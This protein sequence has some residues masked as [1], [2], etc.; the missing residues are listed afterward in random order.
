MCDICKIHCK[1]LK[2]VHFST[3]I[4]SATVKIVSR[5]NPQTTVVRKNLLIR[6]GKKPWA[7]PGLHEGPSSWW[8]QAT[9]TSEKWIKV[10]SIIPMVNS[11]YF[12]KFE[13]VKR[14]FFSASFIIFSNLKSQHFVFYFSGIYTW[15][16][17]SQK[18]HFLTEGIGTCNWQVGFFALVC[19]IILNVQTMNCA[20]CLCSVWD[21]GL[22]WIYSSR[23]NQHE[24]QR[25]V[26][27]WNKNNR[28]AER[29][30]KLRVI[31][32]TL[33]TASATI[34]N[35]PKTKDTTG[36]LSSHTGTPG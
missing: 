7:G 18:Q 2:S 5:Q 36:A 27:W 19:S 28:E 31:S 22:A 16:W 23:C 34:R 9:Q 13:F 17:Y 20:A 32:Q 30:R 35:V 24:T 11:L 21:L 25:A 33:A 6:T 4:A 26:Y 15:S 29:K 14:S 12:Y 3:H 10:L 8:L 1:A